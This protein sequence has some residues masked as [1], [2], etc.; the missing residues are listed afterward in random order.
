M[1]S[2]RFYLL[3]FEWAFGTKKILFVDF[4]NL[5]VDSTDQEKYKM[6]LWRRGL[7]LLTNFVFQSI[8]NFGPAFNV[9]N[10]VIH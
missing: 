7:Y 1:H 9:Y 6:F 10:I 8:K 3:D 2:R 4:D 5:C